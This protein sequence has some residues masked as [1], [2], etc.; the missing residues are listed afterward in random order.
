VHEISHGKVNHLK[1]LVTGGAG[2]IGSHFV[3]MCLTQELGITRVVVLDALTYAG[4]R[5]NLVSIQSD[6][7]YELHV[8]DVCSYDKLNEIM[9]SV[10]AVV[11]F[12]AESH[13]D[14]SIRSPFQFMKTNV[15][16]TQN[17]LEKARLGKIERFVHV[18][19]DE[20][21][22]SISN[23]SWSENELLKPNSPY[24]A[25]KAASDLIALAY[26]KTYALD[27]CVTRSSNN[28]GPYQFPEK[29]IPLF[30]TNI[31]RGRKVPLYGTGNNVRDW[32]HVD[33]HCRAIFAVL[34][35]GKRGEIYN[36]G[37]A[38][39]I[40]NIELTHLILDLMGRGESEISFVEDRLGHDLRYS[41]DTS[42][43]QTQ[44]HYYPKIEFR[45]GLQAT[46]EWYSK[47][48]EWWERLVKSE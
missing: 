10:D 40:T 42:K 46:I 44:L 22:G 2:F 47:N 48:S 43:I 7:R 13:V 31:I 18:S 12:A 16:G 9:E 14:N 38:N 35:A 30:I 39:E 33:D 25:S 11:H 5:Q 1:L 27:V 20:V 26:A 36:I 4:N 37:G 24:S 34:T 8:G 3:R 41:V 19:T 29:L 28:Y 45:S 32:I 15:V 23:G 17:L 21:Y 6:P